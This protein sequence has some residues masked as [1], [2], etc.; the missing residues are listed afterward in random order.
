MKKI[1]LL[2]ICLFFTGCLGH[3]YCNSEYC[4]SLPSQLLIFEKQKKEV[5][6]L[7]DKSKQVELE[8]KIKMK[9]IKLKQKEELLVKEEEINTYKFKV[10]QLKNSK[11]G[12]SKVLQEEIKGYQEAL[13]LC[14]KREYI[15]QEGDCLSSISKKIYGSYSRW[16]CLWKANPNIKNFHLIFPDDI[17]V[18][19][20]IPK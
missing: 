16:L 4:V 8:Q 10:K 19:P 1:I 17:L 18:I 13:K 7:R 6:E 5:K 15:I 3:Q 20:R 11:K 14:N 2:V 9:K 12:E